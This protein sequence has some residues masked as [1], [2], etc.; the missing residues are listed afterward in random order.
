MFATSPHLTYLLLHFLGA[1]APGTAQLALNYYYD[2]TSDIRML[3]LHIKDD[4][5]SSTHNVKG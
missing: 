2:Y 3:T 4:S 5:D 1:R